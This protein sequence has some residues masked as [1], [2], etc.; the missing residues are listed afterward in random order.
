MV[1]KIFLIVALLALGGCATQTPR[2]IYQ[3][4]TKP[5]FVVPKMPVIPKPVLE[6]SK[7]SAADA[8]NPAKLGPAYVLSLRQALNYANL[9]MYEI[10]YYNCLSDNFSVKQYLDFTKNLNKI[11]NNY[12]T[13]KTQ[14]VNDLN[15]TVGSKCKK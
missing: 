10:N 4:V 13:T 9:L 12:E 3:P 6:I 11:I 2:V 8:T 15:M 5:Y 7:L 14:L 1:K